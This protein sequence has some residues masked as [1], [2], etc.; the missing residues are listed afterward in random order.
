VLKANQNEEIY[1]TNQLIKFEELIEYKIDDEYK[2]NGKKCIFDPIREILV[3]STPEE[4]LRQQII[5]Y[6]LDKLRIPKHMIDVEVPMS[7]FKKRARGR[8][9][10]IVYG[11]EEDV[12][13]PLLI[14]ECKA[15]TIPINDFV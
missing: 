3:M 11:K 8:A 1:M 7:R 13:F 6:F 10:I 9:D 12:D 14:V 5:R 4:V 15:P 2:R